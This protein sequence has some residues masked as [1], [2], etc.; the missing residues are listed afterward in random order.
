MI[1]FSVALEERLMSLEPAEQ[2]AELAKL[3]EGIQSAV[4]K[5]TTAGY[6]SLR[7]RLASRCLLSRIA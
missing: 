2:A 5:I 6:R 3:G 1:P 7:V 4:G